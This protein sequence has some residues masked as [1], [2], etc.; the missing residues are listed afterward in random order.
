[1]ARDWNHIK[2]SVYFKTATDLYD[3]QIQPGWQPFTGY[4]FDPTWDAFWKVADY[5]SLAEIALKRLPQQQAINN[6]THL[7]TSLTQRLFKKSLFSLAAPHTYIYPARN[8]LTIIDRA[9]QKVIKIIGPIEAEPES[10][11][12]EK[13]VAKH[14]PFAPKL[15]TTQTINQTYVFT[16]RLHTNDQPVTPTE[17]PEAL[18]SIVPNL[19]KY[20]DS[21]KTTQKNVSEY[22][23]ELQEVSAS[24]RTKYTLLGTEI[25]QITQLFHTL[26]QWLDVSS[27]PITLVMAHGDLTH[28]NI[29]R[30][31]SEFLLCDWMNGGR[32]SLF[33]DLILQEYYRPQ[34]Q[35]WKKFASLTKRD[36]LEAPYFFGI[37]KVFWKQAEEL[38]SHNISL[39][40][41]RIYMIIGLYELALKK[42]RAYQFDDPHSGQKMLQQVI[43]I[44]TAILA[45]RT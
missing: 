24:L 11:L 25:D 39:K 2:T 8:G 20:Y 22:V 7:V 17:W 32:L 27:H 44:Y 9:G 38:V 5:A 21:S 4:Y 13:H 3:I 41:F 34:S 30:N 33:Y 45:S 23:R 43:D 14:C 29:I 12:L 10:L 19:F 37:T 28:N 40:Q 1:M 6:W 36:L 26:N 42:Y 31:S 35:I 18:G 15:I 16:Y